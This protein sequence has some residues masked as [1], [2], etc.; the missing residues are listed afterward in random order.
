MKKRSEPWYRNPFRVGILGTLLLLG[1]YL[2]LREAVPIRETSAL[3]VTARLMY[4]AG[5]LTVVAAAVLLFIQARAPE[6]PIEDEASKQE[7]RPP[8]D[9]AEAQTFED[10]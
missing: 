10:D 8:G 3:T 1:G 4:L 5:F 2:L 7:D 6:P 9:F